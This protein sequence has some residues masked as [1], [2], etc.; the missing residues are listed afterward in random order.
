MYF[1]KIFLMIDKSDKAGIYL[2][3]LL[4]QLLKIR[5]WYNMNENNAKRLSFNKN[6]LTL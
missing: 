4:V 6:N 2:T 3:T 1:L 5:I